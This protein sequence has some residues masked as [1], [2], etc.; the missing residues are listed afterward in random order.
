MNHRGRTQNLLE[1]GWFAGLIACLAIAVGGAIYWNWRQSSQLIVRAPAD[2]S[3]PNAAS[4]VRFERQIIGDP[5]PEN[6][7]TNIQVYDFDQD[8]MNDLIVCDA[9]RNSVLWYRQVSIGHWS[10]IVLAEQ[11]KAPAHAT[12][13]DM[14]ADG[15][16]DVLVSV[17]G[18][19]T[20]SDELIGRVVLLEQQPG[21]AFARHTLLD[22]VRRVADVQPGDFDDDGDLD[23]AVAVFG[24]ARGEVLWLENLGERIFRDQQLLFRP[25]VIHVPVGDL[26]QDGDLDI[27]AIVSQEE[28]ELWVFENEQSGQFTRRRIYYTN[29]SDVGSAGLVMTDLDGDEDLDLLLPQGDNLEDVYAWPQ[30]YHGCLWI[31][32]RGNWEFAVQSIAQF[33]GTYAAAAGDIDADGDRD[34]VL[35]S[36]AND[37][38]D[39]RQ[40]SIIWLENRRQSFKTW[41]VDTDPIRLVTVACGDLNGDGRDDLV[42]GSLHVPPLSGTRTQRIT[43]WISQEADR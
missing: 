39:P 26:D 11:L 18:S 12:I 28:E 40:P 32:N 43:V 29:N 5:H 21:M 14:D 17:L 1:R 24:Y 9:A 33:G 38:G 37:W 31:E 23:L 22:D 7:I 25:G 42:A 10:E 20:P 8:G 36:M 16:Q 2:T 6:R 4:H 19:L 15:D 35:V 41:R 3:I 27:A 30:P 13:V 34:V